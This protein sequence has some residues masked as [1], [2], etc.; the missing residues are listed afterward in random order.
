MQ[1]FKYYTN[2]KKLMG[3]LHTP[4]SLY[5]KVRNLYP[6]S[7][8]L[9]SSDYHSKENAYSY[10]GIAPLASIEI[11]NGKVNYSLPNDKKRND[12]ISKEKP[13]ESILSHFIQSF[14]VEG[15]SADYCGFYGYTAYDCVKYTCNIPIP[16]HCSSSHTSDLYYILYK[17]IIRFDPLKKEITLVEL[18]KDK[19]E[20]SKI[21]S[22]IKLIE[23]RNF[24]SYAFETTGPITS[25]IND[26]EHKKGVEKCIDYCLKGTT[27]QIVFSRSFTQPF[28]GDDFKVYRAL[29]S[30]NPSPYLFYF[31]FGNHRIVGS[32]PETH[33][34]IVG[35]NAYIDPIAGTTKRTG[36]KSVDESLIH[37]LLNDPKENAEHMMLVDLAKKDL[38]QN[39]EK[40][41]VEFLKEPQLYSHVIHLVS[42]VKGIIA[43]KEKQIKLFLDTFPAGTLSG[44]PK[45]KAMELINTLETKTR[46]VYGGCVGFI[47]LNGELNQAIVIRTFISQNNQL[48]F[49]A[50][51]GIVA[52]SVAKNEVNEVKNKLAALTQSI[53]LAKQL[54]D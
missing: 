26:I 11:K 1:Q 8:L 23:D 2:E 16:N 20:E 51:G 48:T 35:N 21:D 4:V 43:N 52:N 29:R 30:I 15:T 18:V 25:S 22:L 44:S 5:L 3:D 28:Q 49:Q 47:G 45:V 46:G 38:S 27:S 24:S 7:V 32:S 17:Y 12:T 41:T 9:E 42:R 54:K 33:C 37:K 36:D 6:Q 31:D 40:V 19:K 39:C 13:L 10:I 14:S 50:G 34:R 53:E